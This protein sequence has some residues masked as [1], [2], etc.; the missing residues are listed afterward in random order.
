[1]K[2]MIMAGTSDAVH[3]ISKLAGHLDLEV[4][5]TTTTSYGGD[6][7]L[8]AGADEIIVGRLGSQEIADLLNISVRTVENHLLHA[9]KVLRRKLERMD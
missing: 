8:S 4:I 6:L 2:I 3:I 5:A 9:L 1:M 7:A